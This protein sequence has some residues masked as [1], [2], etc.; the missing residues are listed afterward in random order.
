MGQAFSG[1]LSAQEAIG[2]WRRQALPTITI[3]IIMTIIITISS[4]T[5][6]LSST[7]YYPASVISFHQ[8]EHQHQHSHQFRQ[9]LWFKSLCQPRG[10]RSQQWLVAS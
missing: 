10:R 5:C 8:H 4:S 3:T 9:A 7:T 2:R 6:Y 1:C